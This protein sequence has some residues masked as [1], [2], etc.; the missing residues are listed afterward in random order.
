MPPDPLKMP[1]LTMS[2]LRFL[3]KTFSK[4]LKF[5]L[6]NTLLCGWFLKNSYIQINFFYGYKLVRAAKRSEL[7]RCS[8]WYRGN[9]TTQCKPLMSF[10]E[11][12]QVLKEIKKKRTFAWSTMYLNEWKHSKTISSFVWTTHFC[13]FLLFPF[14]SSKPF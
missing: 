5:T 8:K 9:C 14:L 3:C 4:L 12:E 2:V 13:V 6:W 10:N 1:S 7:K 11:W